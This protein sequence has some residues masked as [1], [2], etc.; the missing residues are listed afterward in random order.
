MEN[1]G[2]NADVSGF[3]DKAKKEKEEVKVGKLNAADNAFLK[4]DAP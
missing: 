1:T 3:S 4:K 2:G